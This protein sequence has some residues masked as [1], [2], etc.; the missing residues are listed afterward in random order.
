MDI[1]VACMKMAGFSQD[2]NRMKRLSPGANHGVVV[3]SAALLG[4][5]DI[6]RDK[7]YTDKD[8]D[9]SSDQE[10]KIRPVLYGVRLGRVKDYDL[11]ISILL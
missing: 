10:S 2:L 8:Q 4:R 3:S 6:D 7:G 1:E 11:C 5:I 9:S